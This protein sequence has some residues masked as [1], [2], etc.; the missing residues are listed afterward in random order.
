MNLD[1]KLVQENFGEIKE[2]LNGVDDKVK[3]TMSII[4]HYKK[5]FPCEL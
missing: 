4:I 1:C 3:D 5:I 2:T